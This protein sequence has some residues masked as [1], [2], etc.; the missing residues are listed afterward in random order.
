ML[1]SSGDRIP[2]CGVPVSEFSGTPVSVMT[3]AFR[4]ALTRASTRLSVTR[5]RTRSIRAACEI[6]SNEAPSYYPHRGLAVGGDD[7]SVTAPVRGQVVA[8]AGR[9]AQARGRGVA[10][11]VARW[12]QVPDPGGMDRRGFVGCGR[13][14]VDVDA[15]IAVG[16]VAGL[17]A[18][19]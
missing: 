16:A 10:A 12:Q 4:N 17:R 7:Y 19:R 8:G 3:P 15:G 18:G 11:G 5:S 2:P 13:G 6:E 1:A 9:Y 14:S